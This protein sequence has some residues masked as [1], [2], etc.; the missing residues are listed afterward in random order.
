MT[1]NRSTLRR[2]FLKAGMAAAA[3]L[4]IEPARTASSAIAAEKPVRIGSV[5][6]GGRGTALLANLLTMKGV[7]VPA[8]CDIDPAAAAGAE[9]MIVRSGANGLR[10]LPRAMKISNA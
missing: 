4:I 10:P 2:D 7:E 8:V 1:S 5:G 3:G 6:V 9:E